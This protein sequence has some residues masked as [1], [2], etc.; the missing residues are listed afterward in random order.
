MAPTVLRLVAAP[1]LVLAAAF[2]FLGLDPDKYAAYRP[3]V[4]LGK[5]VSAFST[6]LALPRLLNFGADDPSGRISYAIL[7]IAAWDVIAIGCLSIPDKK[8]AATVPSPADAEPESVEI[9]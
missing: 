6:I 2:L 3:L 9:R 4:G 5:A 7:A 1:N 8:P